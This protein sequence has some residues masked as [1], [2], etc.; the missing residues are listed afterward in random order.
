MKHI[1]KLLIVAVTF[2]SCSA[3]KQVAVAKQTFTFD[4]APKTSNKPGS[5]GMV[6]AFVKPY[7]AQDFTSG[8]TELFK[9]FKSA[10]GND[11]EELIIAKG[12]T[13]KGPYQSLD[14]MV[15]EDKKRTDIVI[16]IEIV[17]DFTAVEGNWQSHNAILG[18]NFTSYSYTGKASLV[19]KINLTGVEPLTNEKIWSKSVSIPNVEN[20]E[21]KTSGKYNR[22][23]Q[24]DEILQDPA[25]Y[26]AIGKALQ[27]QYTGILAKIEA[28]FSPEEFGALKNQIKELKSKKGF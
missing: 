13:M 26:N 18:A 20:V 23:L 11:I 21:I 22:P 19:G 10:I 28:H 25:V 2:A 3:T 9:N 8:S 6:Q 7:Y 14:E 24:G 17:P 4:Y 5:V 1:L 27:E 12:F 15:F 16:Q